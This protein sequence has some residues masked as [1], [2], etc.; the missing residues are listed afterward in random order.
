MGFFFCPISIHFTDPRWFSRNVTRIITMLTRLYCDWIFFIIAD[1]VNNIYHAYNLSMIYK[2]STCIYC[3]YYTYYLSRHVPYFFFFPRFYDFYFHS[4]FKHIKIE[5][6]VIYCKTCKTR[7]LNFDFFQ[8][9]P[10]FLEYRYI[11][12]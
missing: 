1:M 9:K 12:F 10:I 11:S 6:R 4:R 8:K 3:I 5:R 7:Y 2:M